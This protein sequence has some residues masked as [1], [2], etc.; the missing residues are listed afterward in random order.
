VPHILHEFR[1]DAPQVRVVLRQ[2]PG[3]ELPQAEGMTPRISF[4][5]ADLITIEGLVGAGLGL[6]ILPEQLAGSFD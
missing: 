2:E 4:E 3:H 1:A 5:S 6:A